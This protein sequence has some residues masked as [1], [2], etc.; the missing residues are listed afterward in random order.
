MIDCRF[1]GEPARTK[2]HV[3]PKWLRSYPGFSATDVGSRGERFQRTEFSPVPDATGVTA[4]VPLRLSNVTAAVC[5]DCNNGWMA[6][7]ESRAQAILDAAMRTDEIA[8][9]ALTQSDQTLL[10]AWFTKCVYAYDAAIVSEPT[11]PGRARTT[12]TSRRHRRRRL[13]QQSGSGRT[14]DTTLT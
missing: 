1:C 7:M 3:W 13:P 8:G 4:S 9:P 12:G 10:A 2:E 14:S 5:R 6:L 11:K